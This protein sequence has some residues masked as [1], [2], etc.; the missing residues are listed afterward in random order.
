[1]LTIGSPFAWP[2][3]W[4][5]ARRR[6]AGRYDRETLRLR[7]RAAQAGGPA[8]ALAL[9]RC[10]HDLGLPSGGAERR[11]LRDALPGLP[12]PARG[13]AVALLARGGPDALTDLPAAWLEA[14][15]DRWPGVA[16]AL[17]RP[18]PLADVARRQAFLEW[19]RSRAAAGGHLVVGNAGALAGRGLG[20]AI[21]AAAAVWRFNR[22]QGTA[23]SPADQGL[24][25][26]VWV[27]SPDVQ[28]AAPPPGLRWAIV[29]GAD[30]RFS[31]ADWRLAER[32][33]GQGVAVLTVPLPVWRGCV[34]QLGAPPSAGVLA[35]AWLSALAADPRDPWR[36][37][38]SVG[39]AEQALVGA[40]YH[41]AQSGARP[42]RRHA[43]PAERDWV[44]RWRAAG[45]GHGPVGS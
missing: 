26:D 17:G 44:E 2:W 34:R 18:H 15:A 7:W 29:S 36:G 5:A 39:I 24:R 35:L 8:E 11:A 33:A 37:V 4:L 31:V 42:G 6:A 19:V 22:W 23:A 27:V 14:A 45:L 41:L 16:E 40:S 12:A 13:Q 3:R 30:P 20:P 43:W 9:A 10:R 28:D 1:V 38:A 25:C 21:D 32:L